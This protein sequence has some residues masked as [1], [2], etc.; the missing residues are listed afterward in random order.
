MRERV[1]STYGAD[2]HGFVY[3]DVS[4][5]GDPCFVTCG[6]SRAACG[7][8]CACVLGQAVKRCAKCQRADVAVML[9]QKALASV[10][11]RE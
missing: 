5:A 9:R 1:Y 7:M 3:D 8:G 2:L 4:R 10:P 6:K 11:I